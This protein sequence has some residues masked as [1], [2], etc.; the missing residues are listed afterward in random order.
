[1]RQY[2]TESERQVRMYGSAANNNTNTSSGSPHLSAATL[3]QQQQQQSSRTTNSSSTHSRG[4]AAI[5][6]LCAAASEQRGAYL[7]RLQTT[8]T[9][10]WRRQEPL[11]A[12]PGSFAAVPETCLLTTA[13]VLERIA[14]HFSPAAATM[15]SSSNT[16]NNNTT[17]AQEP[18]AVLGC[19]LQSALWPLHNALLATWMA[20]ILWM[21]VTSAVLDLTKTVLLGSRRTGRTLAGLWQDDVVFGRTSVQT[22]TE[23]HQP[24]AARC[25]GLL[26]QPLALTVTVAEHVG[27]NDSPNY[28]WRSV[29][30]CGLNGVL[31]WWYWIFLVPWVLVVPFLGTAFG[32]GGCFALI[33]LA[34]HV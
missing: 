14:L 30:F 26:L 33:E 27:A 11:A 31:L 6:L 9:A 5:P 32:L 16:N 20:L 2:L 21:T 22:L 19:V 18:P 10:W 7:R 29:V 4:L 17:M 8:P 34:A 24:V 15:S 12:T 25:V 28:L 3:Q 1:M 23:A 13:A